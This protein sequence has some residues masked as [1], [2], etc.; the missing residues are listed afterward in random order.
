MAEQRERL[1]YNGIVIGG[2]RQGTRSLL[3]WSDGLDFDTRSVTA[4]LAAKGATQEAAAA[5]LQRLKAALEVQSKSLGVTV[6]T[7]RTITVSLSGSSP[8][9]TITRTAGDSFAASD[10]GLPIELAGV[11]EFQI[12]GFT[13]SS[14]VTAEV[15]TAVDSFPSSGTGITATIGHL[16][17]RCDE[18]AKQGGFKARTTFS[19][20]ADSDDTNAR[21]VLSVAWTFQRP[22]I[23]S[24]PSANH[25][26]RSTIVRTATPE[27]F[28]SVEFRGTITAGQQSGAGTLVLGLLSTGLDAWIAATLNLINS[29]DTW[30]E[31]GGELDSFDEE[32]ATLT[33]SRRHEIK[34]FPDLA[35]TADDPRIKGARVSF[36][37]SYSNAHGLP[38]ASA[39]FQVTARYSAGI[40]ARDAT[41]SNQIDFEELVAF[42]GS[43]VKPYL[44]A[45]A[46]ALFSGQVIVMG[47]TDPVYDPVTSRV[48]A[49]IVM[50][51]ADSGSSVF[52]YD[53]MTSMRLSHEYELAKRYDGKPHSYYYWSPGIVIT[54]QVLVSVIQLGDPQPLSRRAGGA[55]GAGRVVVPGGG[56]F[57]NGGALTVNVQAPGGGGGGTAED[58]GNGNGVSFFPDPGDPSRFFGP[59]HAGGTWLQ[60]EASADERVQYW[61]QDPDNVGARLKVT[62]TAYRASYVYV[63]D[64]EEDLDPVRDASGSSGG[65]GAQ[66][67]V[68]D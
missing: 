37:R 1:A 26:L 64:A 44:V 63:I 23:E 68:A 65:Q 61:G 50:L 59:E 14:E 54:G 51:V 19:R 52:Q 53:R 6:G 46:E 38:G 40:N 66:T 9:L 58:D 49:S 60:L 39:P 12:T 16:L 15:N 3:S 18:A 32:Q 29:T 11:G 22:A 13:S 20:P 56:I 41:A 57:F 24:R 35:G 17:V 31:V 67:T 62:T 28:D 33:F 7:D 25:R 45:R 10:V 21:R 27:G 42:W 47:G 8:N 55:S 43:V 36:E 2:T 4:R 48:A 5:E 30:E 34:L